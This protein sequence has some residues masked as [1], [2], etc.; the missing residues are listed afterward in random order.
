MFENFKNKKEIK[1]YNNSI[2]MI[3]KLI[4]FNSI[5]RYEF[6]YIMHKSII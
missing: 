3:Y 2:D 5:I 4:P 6:E 1:I